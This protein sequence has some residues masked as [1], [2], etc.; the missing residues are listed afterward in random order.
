M[1]LYTDFY[2]GLFRIRDFVPD[3]VHWIHLTDHFFSRRNAEYK[4]EK[5]CPFLF[6]PDHHPAGSFCVMRDH[7]EFKQ[8]NFILVGWEKNYG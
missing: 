1:G 8:T 6:L 5:L 2:V 7:C 3:P 4:P